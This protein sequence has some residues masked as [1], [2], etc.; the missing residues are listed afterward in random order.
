[1]IIIQPVKNLFMKKNQ[2]EE[3]NNLDEIEKNNKN[4]RNKNK[5]GGC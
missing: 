1:M 3:N 5:T 2:S 4:F